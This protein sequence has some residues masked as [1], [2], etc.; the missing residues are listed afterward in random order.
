MKYYCKFEKVKSI[1]I[2]VLMVWKRNFDFK[3]KFI[4]LRYSYEFEIIFS[5]IQNITAICEMKLDLKNNFFA[6]KCICRFEK[7][8]LGMT[9]LGH[10]TNCYGPVIRSLKN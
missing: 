6:L 4:D 5:R 2:I 3:N 8:L 1:A 9:L 10:R 7:Y